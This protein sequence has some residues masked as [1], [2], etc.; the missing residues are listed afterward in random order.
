MQ[1][2]AKPTA[3]G[4]DDKQHLREAVGALER[5]ESDIGSLSLEGAATPP[6]QPRRLT[7]TEEDAR[8]TGV[9][10]VAACLVAL[11]ESLAEPV[12]PYAMY[13]RALACQ[14][15]E[16]AYGLV[17]DLPEVVSGLA[18]S[19]SPIKLTSTAFLSDSMQTSFCT[20]SRSFESY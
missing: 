13:G 6:V 16:E 15:R 10:S 5:L 1:S 7:R 4:N 12:I 18:R 19:P 9:R 11:L 8:N 14:K 2:S 3:S 20:F 17:Q